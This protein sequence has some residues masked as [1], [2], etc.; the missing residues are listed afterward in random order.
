[1]KVLDGD[2]SLGKGPHELHK[3]RKEWALVVGI[4]VL[5]LILSWVAFRIFGYSHNLPFE[6]SIFFFGLVNFNII[7]FLLLAFLIFRNVVKSFAEREKSFAG[8]S[9]KSKLIAA[10]VAFS[11]IP[12]TLMFLVSVFYI[13]NSFDKWFS[14]RTSSVLKS[15]LEVM[16]QYYT[17]AKKRNYHFSDT[18]VKELKNVEQNKLNQFLRE[19]I[20]FFKLDA[21]EFYPGLFKKRYFSASKDLSL[22]EL[23]EVSLE[24]KKKGIVQKVEASYLHH[25]GQGNL[26]R[27]IRPINWQG[28]DGAVVVSTFIPLSLISK[29]DDITQA[30]DDFRDSNTLSYPLKSI[31]L[32]ILVLM[33]LVILLAATWFGFY[34][35]KQLSIPLEMLANAAKRVSDQDY[36]QVKIK[37]GSPEI[38]LLVENFNR[39]SE[40]LER[41]RDEITKSNENLQ[42]HTRYI[43]VLLANVTTGVTSINNEGVITMINHHAA[44]LLKIEPQR[45]IGKKLS[46]VLPAEFR[47]LYKELS[48]NMTQHGATT[49]QKEIRLEIAGRSLPLQLSLSILRNEKGE[50]LGKIIVFDDLSM[51][52]NAQ[53]AAAWTEVARRIAHEI[54]NPLTPISLAAQRLERKFGHEVKDKAFTECTH[55]IIEQVDGLKNL[56]NEFSNFARMPKTVP[57]IVDI[58][59]II[60]A[61]LSLYRQAHR[62]FQFKFEKKL[63]CSPFLLDPEQMKR[64]FMNL[65]ENAIDAT[66]NIAH[67]IIEVQGEYD[68]ELKIARVIVLDNGQGISKNLRDRMFEPYVTTKSS[69]TGLGLAIVKRTVED[70]NG[71]IRAFPNSPNGTKIIIELPV[72]GSTIEKTAAQIVDANQNSVD[73]SRNA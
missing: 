24:F 37:S 32:I 2:S 51:V 18:I 1:M 38:N 45:Y 46:A 52:V 63:D 47:N 17:S 34:L 50:E 22:S 8:R 5:F 55:M 44:K 69:G 12:T 68:K 36:H 13:N 14:Q 42:R 16:N 64:V 7:I 26:V 27:I 23:P 54:K 70:H 11:F 61:A 53:R 57:Q 66:K 73:N 28:Q 62:N 49:V 21:I 6:Y 20:E 56:V 15:S 67:P 4:G 71:F 59:H 30:Y 72:L 9:L 43:E 33:T 35:A 29:M 58:N 40:S 10:F 39:M 48:Q 41:S 31:Y 60:E 25:F 19:K 65:F 3:R